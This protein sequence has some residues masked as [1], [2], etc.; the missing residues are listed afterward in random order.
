MSTEPTELQIQQ[1]LKKHFPSAKVKS[2]SRINEGYSHF[3]YDCTLDKAP[4]E[5]IV[6]AG[7][8]KKD[9]MNITKELWVMEQYHKKGV[10]IPKVYASDVNRVK[11]PFDYLV[12]EKLKGVSV[13]K[14]WPKLSREEKKRMMFKLGQ[15]MAKLH[16]VSCKNFGSVTAKGV[17]VEEDFAFRQASKAPPKDEWVHKVMNDA[18]VDLAGVIAYSFLTPEQS[19]KIIHYIHSQTHLVKNAEPVLIHNDFNLPH[20]FVE[21]KDTDWKITG[22]CDFEFASASAREFDFVKLHRAGFFADKELK[23]ALLDGYGR[24]KLNP[25]TDEVVELY[26][27]VRDIGFARYVAKA[28]NIDTAKKAIENILKTVSKK[29]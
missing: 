17:K 2:V 5:V 14:L 1:I 3:M 10:P 24:K 11:F 8:N 21:R 12:M 16:T 29:H 28:G 19:S 27:V 4:K 23:N 25:K 22:I 9:D 26:R 13:E 15:F 20:V 7:Y 18:F 6:R